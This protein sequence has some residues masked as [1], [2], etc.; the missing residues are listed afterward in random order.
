MPI[1]SQIVFNASATA[2]TVFFSNKI[3]IIKGGKLITSGKMEELV[4][5]GNSLE[6]IFM[7]TVDASEGGNG[8]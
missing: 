1:D 5:D 2:S 6:E 4:K 7:E 8:C 3:A